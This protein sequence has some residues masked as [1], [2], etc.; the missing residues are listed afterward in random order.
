M[1]YQCWA[2]VYDA[3]P[4]LIQHCVNVLRVLAYYLSDLDWILWRHYCRSLSHSDHVN[5]NQSKWIH[6]GAKY[7][8][9]KWPEFTPR[10]LVSASSSIYTD[11]FSSRAT[12]A[13]CR[14][15]LASQLP[16]KVSCKRPTSGCPR[17][18]RCCVNAQLPGHCGSARPNRE[19]LK[20]MRTGP[21]RKR[22]W[23]WGFLFPALE[24]LSVWDPYSPSY[25][26]VWIG[27]TLTCT[28]KNVLDVGPAPIHSLVNLILTYLAESIHTPNKSCSEIID[29]ES[30]PWCK[31]WSGSSILSRKEFLPIYI[32]PMTASYDPMLIYCCSTVSDAGQ[33]IGFVSL[34]LFLFIVLVIFNNEKVEYIFT[35]FLFFYYFI[36]GDKL[37]VI[38][39]EAHIITFTTRYGSSTY[40][41][42]N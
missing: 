35:K 12:V 33:S 40:K 20:S 38:R 23:R 36:L 8:L 4:T 34:L 2:S 15:L 29:S 24:V 1:L 10:S 11:P 31:S 32:V 42:I 3:G 7:S 14:A 13:T 28:D 41:N 16:L 21:H 27:P 6:Q 37:D 39:T 26:P 17:P 18:C 9:P 25:S 19:V 5:P 30:Y 22:L